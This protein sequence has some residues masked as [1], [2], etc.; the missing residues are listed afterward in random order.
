MLYCIMF[1]ILCF[2]KQIL[3]LYNKIKYYVSIICTF[4]RTFINHKKSSSLIFLYFTNNKKIE[5]LKILL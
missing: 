4:L 2:P 3:K 5:E 1:E